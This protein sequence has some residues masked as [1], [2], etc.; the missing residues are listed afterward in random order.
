M[1]TSSFFGDFGDQSFHLCKASTKVKA[2]LVNR[3]SKGKTL[4]AKNDETSP[5]QNFIRQFKKVKMHLIAIFIVFDAFL[6]IWR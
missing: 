4:V 6:A 2:T 1:A 5:F 3:V